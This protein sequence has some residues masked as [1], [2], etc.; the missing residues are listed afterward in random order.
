G[1]RERGQPALEV[2]R[3]LV[4][5]LQPAAAAVDPGP[6]LDAAHALQ[7][8][9]GGADLERDALVDLPALRDAVGAL[10]PLEGAVDRVL[11]LLHDDLDQVRRREHPLL[12][13]DGA[14][15]LARHH[16]L[17]GVHVLAQGD[18]ALAQQQLA[19][20]VVGVGGGGEDEVAGLHDHAPAQAHVAQGQH[21]REATLVERLEQVRYVA[22]GE[23][24]LLLHRAW[25]DA[26]LPRTSSTNRS[27]SG[28]AAACTGG[29]RSTVT[30][31]GRSEK[32]PLGRSTSVPPTT[33]G[34]MRLSASMAAMK[35]PFLNSPSSPVRLR[36]P[37][38]KARKPLPARSEATAAAIEARA[39]SRSFRST[40]MRPARSMAVPRNGI[41]KSSFLTS[42]CKS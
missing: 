34:T 3:P 22:L 26:I 23:T 2:G 41:L 13:Q 14:Q 10:R 31:P 25:D 24:T 39:R 38:G 36:V 17:A 16:G 8:D 19:H 21:S 15:P 40:G 35:T 30:V 11:R 28:S 5:R 29:S 4:A 1:Q 6:G 12:H 32:R 7:D 20:A 42:T 33:T 37:S 9:V 27:R 18:A